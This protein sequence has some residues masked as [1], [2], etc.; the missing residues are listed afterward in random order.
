M[1]ER[2]IKDFVWNAM[3]KKRMRIHVR[4]KAATIKIL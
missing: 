4:V 1:T 3:D 2:I